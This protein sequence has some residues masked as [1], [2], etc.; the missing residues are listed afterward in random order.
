M[1]FSSVWT[2]VLLAS[3]LAT[4]VA[5]GQ[6]AGSSAG[7]LPP[8]RIQD[9]Q[10]QTAGGAGRGYWD[11]QSQVSR[12]A[13][14]DEALDANGAGRDVLIGSPAGPAELAAPATNGLP[15]SEP[16]PNGNLPGAVQEGMGGASGG[17]YDSNGLACV[18]DGGLGGACDPC[19][20]CNW[21]G[22]IYGLAMQRD[23]DYEVPLVYP[24]GEPLNNV[25]TTN[26]A[27]FDYAGGLEARLGYYL[28]D[29]WAI[30]GVYWGLWPND[31]EL[32]LN[33]IGYPAGLTSGLNFGTL[34]YDNGTGALPLSTYFTGAQLFTLQRTFDY[35]NVE[36]NML[37]NASPGGY[38]KNSFVWLAG[39]RYIHLD[40]TFSLAADLNNTFLGDDPLNELYYD[41]N[42]V[43][44]L[45]GF[46]LGGIWDRCCTSHL[47]LRIGSKVGIYG[48]EIEHD[49]RIY[50]GAGVDATTNTGGF[51]GSAY[52]VRSEKEDVSWGSELF[53]AV[54]Y[55]V[56][57]NWRLTGGYRALILSDV[58]LPYGQI[59]YRFSDL[60]EA[61]NIN[62]NDTLL[63]HGI[64]AGLEYN[65]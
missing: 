58:A 23:D 40:E 28:N 35:H 42:V 43:N 17:T 60:Q 16:L 18:Y 65:W 54:T 8:T 51:A 15:A 45:V 14:S 13:L 1:K 3:Q 52:N 12:V 41:I 24:V 50:S 33:A 27:D 4:G 57:H 59:P 49:Q 32:T 61:G 29:C 38:G 62:A 26:S 22:G 11:Y 46:Q 7:L 31:Q 44:R 55:R 37:R 10:S 2:G 47:G 63:L 6:T 39:I 36:L 64:F 20:G 21:F 34:N 48:N 30:E 53:A 5:W 9:Y 19:G 25:I 56:F